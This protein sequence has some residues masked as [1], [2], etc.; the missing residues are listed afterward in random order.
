MKYLFSVFGHTKKNQNRKKNHRSKVWFKVQTSF[1]I[2]KSSRKAV[3][4]YFPVWKCY[5]TKTMKINRPRFQFNYFVLQIEVIISFPSSGTQNRTSSRTET[6]E[7][8]DFRHVNFKTNIVRPAFSPKM[9][10]RR[11]WCAWLGNGSRATK[12]W[13]LLWLVSDELLGAR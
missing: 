13:K 3:I 11:P 2:S 4:I 5:L 10:L 9:I 6:G 7:G 12:E 1:Q 8:V